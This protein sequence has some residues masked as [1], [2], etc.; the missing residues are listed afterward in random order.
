MTRA[1]TLLLILIQS[2]AMSFAGISGDSSGSGEKHRPPRHY[3]SATIYS[4]YYYTP[5]RALGNN[6]L[7]LTSYQ[8]TQSSTGFYVPLIT[9]DY[10]RSD[11]TVLPNLSILLVGNYQ[12]STPVFGGLQSEH[13]LTKTTVGFRFF[14]NN[15]KKNI[16]FVNIGPLF[17]QDSRSRFDPVKHSTFLLVFN[18]T[19]S[20]KFSWRLGFTKTFI[21][22]N[23]FHL[24]V[25]GLRFG[26]LDGT[27]FSIQFPRNMSINFPMGRQF[28]GSVYWKPMGGLYDFANVD[29]IKTSLDTTLLYNGRDSIVQFGRSEFIVGANITWSPSRF[30]SCF[31]SSG[32][33]MAN[34]ISFASYQNNPNK[35]KT[36]KPFYFQSVRSSYFINAGITIRFGKV[37]KVYNNYTMYDMM[38]LNNTFDPGDNNDNIGNSDIPKPGDMNTIRKIQYKDVEDLL[39][40][41]DIY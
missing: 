1:L 18:R 27:Y 41:E 40:I 22:G 37:K 4:N 17:T 30:F 21:F 14:Y 24:P 13:R 16:W 26:R 33:T 25:I 2:S 5:R 35:F 39:E 6:K 19:E 34:H 7:G 32:L 29:S 8:F 36:L 10:H 31:V 28:S 11:S 20:E 3:F 23:K 12:A 15:G 9:R 38:D